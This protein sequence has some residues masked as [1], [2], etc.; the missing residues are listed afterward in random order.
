MPDVQ[1]VFQNTL[2]NFLLIDLDLGFTFL[3]TAR[4]THR[5]G[6]GRSSV[7]KAQAAL[8]AVRYFA[9]EFAIAAFPN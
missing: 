9:D 5:A 4:N 2:A 8:M 6:R 7:E 1:K 3:E